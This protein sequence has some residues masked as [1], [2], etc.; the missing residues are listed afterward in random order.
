M[1]APHL[2]FY[3]LK[4]K[5]PGLRPQG[6]LPIFSI[7][8]AIYSQLRRVRRHAIRPPK[9]S[10]NSALDEGSGTAAGL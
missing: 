2:I 3:T 8:S 6:F 9:P 4:A 5:T 1:R 10:A 7:L